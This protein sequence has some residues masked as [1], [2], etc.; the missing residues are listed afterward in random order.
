MIEELTMTETGMVEIKAAHHPVN[1]DGV[2]K[3]V[4]DMVTEGRFNFV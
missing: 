3:I 1:V 4:L 2:S